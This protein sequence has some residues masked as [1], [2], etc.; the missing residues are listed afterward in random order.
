MLRALEVGFA[1]TSG[2]AI[3]LQFD[4]LH[5]AKMRPTE[6][7]CTHQCRLQHAIRRLEKA[8]GLPQPPRHLLQIAIRGL[9]KA[10]Y[11]CTIDTNITADNKVTS[12]KGLIVK[13]LAFNE[14]QGQWGGWPTS[15]PSTSTSF[16]SANAAT[17]HTSPLPS[18]SMS[19]ATTAA[20]TAPTNAKVLAWMSNPK[21]MNLNNE[22]AKIVL[23]S[24]PCPLHCN[25]CKGPGRH[26]SWPQCKILHRDK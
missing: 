15:N 8:S 22:Q 1:S 2:E 5:D 17:S 25:P 16:G 20:T 24:H 21:F 3:G 13:C 11:Q 12:I 7:L 18:M 23:D 19:P 6:H 4:R 10:R 14:S 26:C 9:N